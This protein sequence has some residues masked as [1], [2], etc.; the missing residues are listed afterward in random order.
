MP[1]RSGELPHHSNLADATRVCTDLVQPLDRPG[2]LRCVACGHRCP[3]GPDRAGVC[4]V[5]FNDEAGRLH[6]PWGYSA[7]GLALDPIEKKPFFH[8]LPGAGA[9]SFG[10]LGCNFHCGYCQNWDTSQVLRDPEAAGRAVAVDPAEIVRAATRRGARVV[11]STYNEPLITAEWAADVFD[12]AHA[13]GLRTAMVSNGHATPEVLDFLRPR[14]DLFKVDLKSFRDREYRRLGGALAPVL[15]GI[16]LAHE[17]GLWVEVVTLVVPRLN[18][19]P[20]ELRDM[21]EFLAGVSPD[22]PWHVTAFHPDY[23]MR[24]RGRTPPATLVEAVAIGRTAGLRFVYAGN[25]PGLGD[26]ESTRC[27]GCGGLLVERRGFTVGRVRIADG[28]CPDC[29]AAVPGV[30]R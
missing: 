18:D 4:R 24:D 22:L 3:I 23:R 10:M 13:A 15:D 20:A 14:M 5:R 21:A 28:A 11:V 6:V 9:L 16:R 27:P 19:D 30:W 29:G 8:V 7:Y 2:W 1:G 12:A 17:R 25:V 26:L